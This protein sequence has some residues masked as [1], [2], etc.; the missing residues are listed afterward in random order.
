M[1]CSD[2][3]SFTD[4]KCCHESIKPIARPVVPAPMCEEIL[5]RMKAQ[6][7]EAYE[8]YGDCYED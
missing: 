1:S 4:G 3:P 5:E 7:D 8:Y 6:Y 2:C